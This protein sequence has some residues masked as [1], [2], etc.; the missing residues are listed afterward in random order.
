MQ[1]A[2][3]TLDRNRGRGDG[4]RNKVSYNNSRNFVD[5]LAQND[6][7]SIMTRKGMWKTVM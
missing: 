6:R 4:F 5:S 2:Q 7:M 1:S 3:D